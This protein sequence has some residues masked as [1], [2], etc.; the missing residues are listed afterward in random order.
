MARHSIGTRVLPLLC[1]AL[2]VGTAPAPARA[3]D[4]TG[5]RLQLGLTG[6][7]GLGKLSDAIEANNPN[8]QV[9]ALWPVGLS[10][11]GH[12]A[13][14]AGFAVSGAIGPAIL[15]FGD[16]SLHVVP[17]SLGLRWR[18]LRSEGMALVLRLA[19]ETMSAGGDFLR[20]GSDGG[21]AG[22]AFEFGKPS[23][24]AWGLE[25]AAHS[26][27]VIVKATP[28]RAERK[29]KPLETTLT[30]FVSF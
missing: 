18:A 13:I 8:V 15:G 28:G 9:D 30:L 16:A 23:Q 24:F 19:A 7:S 2:L 22:I 5:F 27:E 3:Q 26:G 10:L 6:T 4:D 25:L 1:A 14:G 17:V 20:K 21:V 11:A 29:V 12:Y